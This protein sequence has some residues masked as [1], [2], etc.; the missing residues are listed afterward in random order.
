MAKVKKTDNNK[1][2][3]QLE[4]SLIPGRNAKCYNL[5]GKLGG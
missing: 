4:F 5:F 1:D 2:V 3:E